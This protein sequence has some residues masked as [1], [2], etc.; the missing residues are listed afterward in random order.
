MDSEF[1]KF[2]GNFLLNAAQGQKQLEQM[3]TWMKQGFDNFGDIAAMFGQFYGIP[4][5]STPAA[6]DSRPKE[7]ETAIKD[8]QASFANYSRQWGWVPEKEHN[9]LIKENERLR[10]RLDE[11]GEVIEQ[12]RQLL[13]EKGLGHMEVFQRM[14][15]LARE[16]N[17]QFHRFMQNFR[18]AMDDDKP[19]DTEK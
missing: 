2:W 17:Q 19:T 16:Q 9:N 5:G 15:S 8:F 7:W 1:L 12:L 11:Q 3:S 4:P 6:E 10:R 13:E 18:D 14:Q